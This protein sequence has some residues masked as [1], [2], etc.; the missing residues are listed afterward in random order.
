MK[1]TALIILDGFGIAPPSDSN[2]IWTAQ[3]PFIDSLINIYPTHL[4]Y[5]SGINVGLPEGEVG[6]SEVGHLTIGSGILSYQS[7]P[8]IDQAIESGAF[9][10]SEKLKAVK[11]HLKETG[12]KLHVLGLIGNGG[13]H[14]H[15]R[16]LDAVLEWSHKNKLHKKTY[17]HAFLDGRDTQKDLGA[18]FL[19]ELLATCEKQKIAGVATV[20]GRKLA[21]DRNNNWDRIAQAYNAI[22][23]G[24]ASSVTQSP[25]EAVQASYA[26]QI[27]D[28]ELE[29]IVVSDKKGSPLAIFEK[30]DAIIFFNFRA[31][32]AR[33]LTHAIVDTQFDK[34]NRVQQE[35]LHVL[36]F[37]EYEKGLS[38][39]V[40]FDPELIA[41]P[42]AKVVS[43][44]GLKQLHI[45]ETEKYAHVTF[46]IN[47]M[48]EAPFT[49]ED[50]ELIPSPSVV[51]Y[52]AQP[53]M[54]AQ[55]VTDK[56]LESLEGQKHDFY[57]INYANP[58]MVGHTGNLEA[59]KK[60]VEAT[61]S[62]LK[63]VVDKI[64]ELGGQAFVVGD[65][66]N[67]EE[68]VHPV[69]GRV[70]KEHNNYPVPFILIGE[71]FK[72]LRNT[73]VT[74]E[75]LHLQAPIGILADVA[76]T[77]LKAVTLSIPE[78]MTGTPLI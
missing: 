10:E 7:L 78:E 34:F 25:I 26:N 33:E 16:H 31:D 41:N 32:R 75:N 19:T 1:P 76:P 62:A 3:T 18:Q 63:Q 27:F 4:L 5:A 8:R 50:R 60:A 17:I 72:E 30:G 44:A 38:V 68:L 53:A 14:S 22:A 73:E 52:D 74:H 43:D 12:G 28:E 49:L 48:T 11:N 46:F 66:G 40:L 54:S 47:G 6:N 36:T 55:L 64:L 39:D 24:Q 67:A 23:L 51:S 71:R 57:I 2:A 59:S 65:H 42:L 13:V 61:D 56:I 35:N 69:T 70:D 21:M 58:D 77:V 20:C 29:P 45:A 9:F 37:T 15:S